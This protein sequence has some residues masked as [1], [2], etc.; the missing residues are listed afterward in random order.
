[1]TDSS[2]EKDVAELVIRPKLQKIYANNPF[3]KSK[4]ELRQLFIE[5]EGYPISA[6]KFDEYL[7][8]LDIYFEKTVVLRGLYNEPTNNLNVAAARQQA[9]PADNDEVVFDN[10]DTNLVNEVID[11]RSGRNRNDMFGLA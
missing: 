8:M 9:G 4:T 1:M 7:K 10:E 3:I 11:Q 2:F 5:E 6:A